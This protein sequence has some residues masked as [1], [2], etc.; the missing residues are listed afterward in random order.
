MRHS[1]R[2]DPGRYPYL[3]HRVVAGRAR[4]PIGFSHRGFAPEGDEN[5][6]AA[7]Q[8]AVELGFRYL[9]IDVRASSDGQVMVFH[10]EDLARV[11]DGTGPIADR[12]AAELSALRVGGGGGVPTL[13]EVLLRWPGLRLNIDVKSDDCVRPFAE[14]VNRLAAHDR[15]LVASFSDRRRRRVL[16]LLDR[17]T[18]SSAGM[19]VNALVKLSAPLGLAAPI[20]RGAG[21]QALQVPE[22]HR[23]I[24]VV[25]PAFVARC[26]AAGVQVHVWTINERRDMDRLLDLGVDGL[27][28]DAADVLA[29]C[30]RE[31]SAWTGAQ[32]GQEP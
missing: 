24:R 13:A 32:P 25:T 9:E 26:H 8:R 12:T 1:G 3:D 10:D 22:R 16:R 2:P 11:T 21:V 18:A 19:M 15:V 29:T 5:T 6:M 7:F 30:L 20:A 23:G 14:L 4:S 31:R 28:S 27:V 17:P